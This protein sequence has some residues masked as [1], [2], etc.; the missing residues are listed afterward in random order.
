MIL[1]MGVPELL[2]ILGIALVIFGPKNLPKLGSALGK[3]VKNVR[4]GM[5][6]GESSE[7]DAEKTDDKDTK[8][9][10]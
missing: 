7:S 2:L 10:E 1:G 5:E 6:E 4:E 3:T 9:T 8:D